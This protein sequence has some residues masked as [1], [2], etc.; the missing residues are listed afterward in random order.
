MPI[1]RP[2]PCKLSRHAIESP[3]GTFIVLHSLANSSDFGLL[4]KQS[5]PK[6]EIP[7][8]GRQ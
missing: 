5:S 3:T 7:C 2:Y 6:W 1:L 8:V 4:G